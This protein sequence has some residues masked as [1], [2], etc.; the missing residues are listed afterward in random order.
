MYSLWTSHR[1]DHSRVKSTTCTHIYF[2][3]VVTI[4]EIEERNLS[5][6]IIII[7]IKIK[8][9]Y[10][11]SSNCNSLIDKTMSKAFLREECNYLLKRL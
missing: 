1:I 4:P 5:L 9:V 7:I 3:L 8:I 11:H 2:D 10:L 6:I